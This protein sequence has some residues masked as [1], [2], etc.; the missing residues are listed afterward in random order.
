M[1]RVMAVLVLLFP[2]MAPLFAAPPAGVKRALLIG[3]SNYE[4]GKDSRAE[5]WNLSSHNDVVL[6]RKTITEKRFG[7]TDVRVV[8][9]YSDDGGTRFVKGQTTRAAILAAIAKLVKDTRPGDI[10]YIHY[11]GHGAGI[12]D[13]SGDEID[14]IDES[15]VPSDYVS[16]AEGRNNL[17]DDEIGRQLDLLAGKKPKSITVTLDSCFSGSGT[18]GDLGLVPRG[19]RDARVTARM[20]TEAREISG[21][22]A[23]QRALKSAVIL[24]A[25]RHDQVA[26]ENRAEK[27]GLMTWALVQA[28]REANEKT[29]YRDLHEKI[30]ALV[31][32]VSRLQ[33]P[34]VEGAWDRTLFEG[35]VRAPQPYF[36]VKL[37]ESA[38]TLQGGRIHGIEQNAVVAL[39]PPGTSSFDGTTQVL[40]RARVARATLSSAVLEL[41]P[42]AAGKRPKRESLA[43]ARAVVE[44]NSYAGNRLVADLT[45]LR[46]TD[47]GKR[48]ARRLVEEIGFLDEAVGRGGD[49]PSAGWD[50]RVCAG[51]C[52]GGIGAK[53]GAGTLVVHR[54][55]GSVV[56]TIGPGEE[57]ISLMEGALKR[58]A[59]QNLIRRM[60]SDPAPALHSQV[61]VELRIVRASVD[62][63]TITKGPV[64]SP[65]ADGRLHLAPG[66]I[67]AF[68]VRNI[69]T[70]AAY[71]TVLDI[72]EDEEGQMVRPVWPLH[73]QAESRDNVIG[74][75]HG[76][77]PEARK[78]QLLPEVVV[79]ILPVKEREIFKLIALEEWAD[80]RSAVDP[81][82][83]RRGGQGHPITDLLNDATEGTRG[84]DREVRVENWWVAEQIAYVESQKQEPAPPP[85]ER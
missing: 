71:V 34:Q 51:P 24:S 48:V 33:Q 49:T 82:M 84:Q 22:G 45:P 37:D 46:A 69:G 15:L 60:G 63:D 57:Q 76:V 43:A 38:L 74:V 27:V 67:I 62:G 53:A 59:R 39:Y 17:R 26:Y 4:R 32:G 21:M 42:D 73:A 55:D 72:F 64:V 40:A 29:T 75:E 2:A 25:A 83:T 14:G 41:L 23:G 30:D 8:S 3:V 58:E 7:F 9:D 44:K 54:P 20:G 36:A 85:A 10:V 31:A 66:D 12:A 78:W 35:T 1:H 81:M 52:P 13:D 77:P 65:G 68:E 79:E 61:K 6:L 80:I 50:V 28:L 47:S 19:D 70:R 11:S 5:W 56:T 18:R 16:R